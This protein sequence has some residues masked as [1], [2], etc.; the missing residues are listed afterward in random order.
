MKVEKVTKNGVDLL[1]GILYS[2]LIYMLIFTDEFDGGGAAL[3]VVCVIS[4]AVLLFIQKL[5]RSVL[6]TIAR[7]FDSMFEKG[8]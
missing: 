7:S 3:F 8:E 4:F 5:A 6:C 2:Y 1:F